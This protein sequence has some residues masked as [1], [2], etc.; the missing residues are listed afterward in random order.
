MRVCRGGQWDWDWEGGWALPGAGG[1]RGAAQ[2]REEKGVMSV[3]VHAGTAAEVTSPGAKPGDAG[4][5]FGIKNKN[6]LTLKRMALNVPRES[7]W[8]Q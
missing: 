7:R 8:R 4:L 1:A 3:Q 2:S 6:F 5:R